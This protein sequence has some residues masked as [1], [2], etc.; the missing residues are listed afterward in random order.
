[1]IK[2]YLQTA[3]RVLLRNRGYASIN[4]FGLTLG[5]TCAFMIFLIV[6]FHLS[7]NDQHHF[8][9]RIYRVTTTDK[10]AAQ[11]DATSMGTPY[12]LSG[13]LRTGF[14]EIENVAVTDY[15]YNGQVLIPQQS[16]EPKKFS[17]TSGIAF[18]QPQFF[19]MF[20]FPWIEGTPKTLDE[21]NTVALSQTLSQK[22][23][24]EGNPIGKIIRL[25]NEHD[26]KVT[27]IF[28]DFPANSDFPFQMAIAFETSRAMYPN[29]KTEWGSTSSNTNTYVLFKENFD[30]RAAETKL[31]EE[32][33][34]HRE[35]R[36]GF[37][38]IF[39]FQ[40]LDAIHYDS[41]FGSYAGATISQNTLLTLGLIGFFL[42][43]TACINFVN[44]ATAQAVKRA[45]EVGVR[46]VLGANRFQ[47]VAQFYGETILITLFAVILTFGLTEF[48]F[49]KVMEWL[50]L[51][52]PSALIWNANS[53]L[54]IAALSV[55]VIFLAGLYP[56]LV[57]S[58]FGPALALKSKI[59]SHH[60]GGLYLRKG[61]VVLQFSISQL[62]IIGT[63][64]AT[65]Q[66]DFFNK[67]DLGFNK[68][69]VVIVPIHE[70]TKTLFESL[71]HQ[72]KSHPG[73]E[74]VS[75]SYA[76][77]ASGNRWTSN[78]TF[79]KKDEP[80]ELDVDLKMADDHYADI[81]GLQ[82][83]AGRNY[84]AGD[85]LREV[86]INE[87]MVRKLG[88]SNP[89]DAI[90]IEL[91]IGAR[92]RVS[93]VGV[94]RDF[95]ASSLHDPIAPCIIA[96]NSRFYQEASIKINMQQ[97]TEALRH[98]ETVWNSAFPQYVFDRRFQDETIAE[99]YEQ[100]QIY[101]NMLRIFS[102]IAI[103]IGCLGLFGLVSFMATQKTKEIG[104]RKVL[105][106]S[107]TDILLI[108]GKEF[109]ALIILAFIIAAP[110]AYYAMQQW[111]Q[112]F[113]YRITLGPAVFAAAV[114]A[115][116]IIAGAT[117]GYQV[118][119]AA[120]ANPADALKYE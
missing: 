2:N 57:L 113:E 38:R 107:V 21:L 116:L 52:I 55:V 60:S 64:I 80:I 102:G 91:K 104:V 13:L 118:F 47:L 8:K 33:K 84:V 74:S 15:V 99:F 101:T 65:T 98:I 7:F 26:L 69:A 34:K 23:F 12:P 53:L 14:P 76:S 71:E 111:L 88:F 3:W 90:G 4:I 27:G 78:I 11:E 45:K 68:E 87:T 54:F 72:W 110:L 18:V 22:Y 37:D 35:I 46:K 70:R 93:V 97:A 114:M 115:S 19:D 92:R 120:R 59:T 24:P 44:L 17:E 119:R 20:D 81:F 40:P 100:E 82:F 95:N 105:G 96:T 58:G 9:D 10:R 79:L 117:V 94:V 39:L 73:V 83:I 28:K 32:A 85:T 36:P 49:P 89:Q 1:M 43:V 50:D 66:L 67:Q 62:L 108:F 106:A 48:S 30:L 112:D 63:I 103:F 25:D 42:I 29:N 56:A 51:T 86:L 5:M 41:H 16:G 109:I 61:L 75:F 77:A 31:N 6:R